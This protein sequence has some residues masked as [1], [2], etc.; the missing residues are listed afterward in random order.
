MKSILAAAGLALALSASTFAGA[1]AAD[2]Y[3]LDPSHSQI[4]FSYDHLGF[5]T[6]YGLISGFDG[7]MMLDEDAI[8]NS[9]VEL[10]ISLADLFK[11]GWAD[12]DTHFLSADFLNV[13]ANPIATFKSTGVEKTGDDTAKIT[14]DLT[15]AGNTQSVVLD[16]KLN[17]IGEHP[18]NKKGW[19]GFDATTTIKR[20]DFGVNKFQG[21]GD[22]IAITI[23]VEAEKLA[24]S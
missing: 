23:S 8:E 16:A 14:G 9:S 13:E 11:T 7:Q 17:K 3:K 21:V 6:T 10:E 12:R 24:G 4:L 2:N 19:A 5:S 22:E 1:F 18:L 20:A 15:I